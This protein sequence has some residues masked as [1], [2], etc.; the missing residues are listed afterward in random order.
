VVR[1]ED[2]SRSNLSTYGVWGRILPTPLQVQMAG[3]T[4]YRRAFVLREIDAS[5]AD[6]AKA[7][8]AAK[9]KTTVSAGSAPLKTSLSS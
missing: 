6:D 4:F 2:G 5:M 1:E 3:G 7:G 8:V 9:A